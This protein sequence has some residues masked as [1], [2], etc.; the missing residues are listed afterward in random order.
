MV[1]TII[2]STGPAMNVTTSMY[3]WYAVQIHRITF[4]MVSMIRSM[5][6]RQSTKPSGL[7]PLHFLK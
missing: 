7:R 2:T 5:C 1:R 4:V 6:A 3:Q